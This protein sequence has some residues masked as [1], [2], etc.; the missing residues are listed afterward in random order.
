M[1]IVALQVSFRIEESYSLKGKRRIVSSLLQRCQTKFKV[2][3]AEIS[4]LD[5][6][7]RALIGMA[8]VTNNQRHGESVLQKCLDFIEDNYLIEVTAVEW[9]DGRGLF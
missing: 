4:D 1:Y 3:I 2:S 5:S 9:L 7:T 6:Q 8:I